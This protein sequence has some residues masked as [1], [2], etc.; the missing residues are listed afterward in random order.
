MGSLGGELDR[1][2]NTGGEQ[3]GRVKEPARKAPEREDGE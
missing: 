1:V 3:G 2:V